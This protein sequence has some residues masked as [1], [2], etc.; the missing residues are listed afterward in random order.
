MTQ[1]LPDPRYPGENSTEFMLRPARSRERAPGRPADLSQMSYKI[2]LKS[3]LQWARSRPT[4][5]RPCPTG[6]RAR[7]GTLSNQSGNSYQNPTFQRTRLRTHKINLLGKSSTS[8]IA[9]LKYAFG[10]QRLQMDNSKADLSQISC[11]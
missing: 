2:L 5:R 9:I 8:F 11:G 4:G 7:A 1:K 6:A 3:T 10:R